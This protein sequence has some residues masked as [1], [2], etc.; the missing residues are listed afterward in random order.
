MTALVKL[1][2]K[3]TRNVVSW[4]GARMSLS[5]RLSDK[6]REILELYN[7]GVILSEEIRHAA[8]I[9]D[10]QNR[11]SIVPDR[12]TFL[13]ESHQS[14]QGYHIFFYPFEG[15]AIHELMS[16]LIAYRISVSYPVT[17]SMAMN[18]YGFELLCDSY[19]NV[20]EIL[21]EDIFTLKNLRE[22]ILL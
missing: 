17:F 7:Q 15:R 14:N 21:E 19:L 4:M 6:I 9:L 3:K 20:E 10:L 1:S 11:L 5:S 13:I 22:D 12:E 2:E 16:A 18:D 8:P